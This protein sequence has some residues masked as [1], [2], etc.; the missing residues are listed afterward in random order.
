MARPPSP[1]AFLLP[2]LA[3]RL[4]LPLLLTACGNGPADGG[5]GAVQGG[6]GDRGFFG[7]SRPAPKPLRDC[8]GLA[9][10]LA[11]HG[12]GFTARVERPGLVL[13]ASYRPAACTACMENSGAAFADSLFRMRAA[14]LGRSEL[15]VLKLSP[16]KAGR[17]GMAMQL[18]KDLAGDLVEVVGQD[19]FP[20]SFI[21]VEA[22]PSL[23]PYGTAL[24]GF[25]RPQDGRDRHLV[26]RDREG[27]LGGDLVL[28][29]PQGRLAAY[30]IMA[31]DS[32]TS[33]S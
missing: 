31:P 15:Y 12:D 22:L 8:A 18:D 3:F 7:W 23:L 20:C 5:G 30:L 33:A 11:G 14:E 2:A 28:S 26:L 32:V 25:D 29:F 4:S 13:E 27:R 16:G 17:D 19:T 24:A 6:F 1:H 9:K 10:W 21:H